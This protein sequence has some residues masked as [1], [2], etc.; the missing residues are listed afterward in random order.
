MN[1][2]P[3]LA[4]QREQRPMLLEDHIGRALTESHANGGLRSAPSHGKPLSW[5]TASMKRPTSGAW[6]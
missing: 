6:A 5:A 2:E 3:E 1:D 4:T